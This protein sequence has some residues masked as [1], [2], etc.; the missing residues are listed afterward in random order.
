MCAIL[1]DLSKFK[2]QTQTGARCI[3][4]VDKN[5]TTGAD[6]WLSGPCG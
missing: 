4:S 1:R 5:I 2:S 3:P 6:R